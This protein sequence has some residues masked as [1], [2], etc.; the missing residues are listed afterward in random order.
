[1]RCG[2][3]RQH[4][5]SDN[6][7]A[8]PID[9]REILCNTLAFCPARAAHTGRG[10]SLANAR[11]AVASCY[12]RSTGTQGAPRQIV[13][14]HRRRGFACAATPSNSGWLECTVHTVDAAS[15]REPGVGAIG[16]SAATSC[17]AATARATG[18][19]AAATSC[20]ASPGRAAAASRT[21]G[22]ASCARAA[23][24][25][26]RNGA[27]ASRSGRAGAS[28]ARACRDNA[29]ALQ[30]CSPTARARTLRVSARRDPRTSAST[31]RTASSTRTQALRTR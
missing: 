22:V 17:S 2:C 24:A 11:R 18:T 21:R 5:L 26:A 9:S 15:V 6:R 10:S 13:A 19:N 30:R 7:R 16:S 4:L 28:R 27:G 12:A 20:S 23:A 3:Q 31:S 8:A 14:P 25:R 1:M 29:S